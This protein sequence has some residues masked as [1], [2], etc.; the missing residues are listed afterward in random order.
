MS[1]NE[2][3]LYIYCHPSKKIKLPWD[4]FCKNST[5]IESKEEAYVLKAHAEKIFLL[6]KAQN[7][8]IS[9]G[10]FL[11]PTLQIWCGNRDNLRHFLYWRPSRFISFYLKTKKKTRSGKVR[12]IY[13]NKNKDQQKSPGVTF[14]LQVVQTHLP[15][16]LIIDL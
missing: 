15:V 8:N 13:K 4:Q 5:D 12:E 6:Q 3:L 11:K 10:R 2:S 16:I 1:P 7:K 9:S 14:V